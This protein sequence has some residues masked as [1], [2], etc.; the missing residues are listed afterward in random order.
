[1]WKSKWNPKHTYQSKSDHNS[2]ISAADMFLERKKKGG[3][4]L[5]TLVWNDSK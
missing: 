1:M 4:G 2:D 5:R 3:G